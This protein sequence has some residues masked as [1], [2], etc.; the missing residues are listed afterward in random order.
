MKKQ[1][2]LLKE[3]GGTFFR[4]KIVFSVVS[5]IL[6]YPLSFIYRCILA[7]RR[8]SIK[9][10]YPIYKSPIPVIAVGNIALGGTGK[11]PITSHILSLCEQYGI[12]ATLISRGY[13]GKAKTY[14]VNLNYNNDPTL[15]GDE[16]AMMARIHKKTLCLVDPQRKRAMLYA[17][18]HKNLS[19]FVLDDAMQHIYVAR[20][21][22]V[23]ILTLKDICSGWDRVLPLGRWREGAHALHDASIFCIRATHKE[24]KEYNVSI[25]ER[26]RPYKKAVYIFHVE[27]SGL[28]NLL[29][30]MPVNISV[31]YSIVC[32]VGNPQSFYQGM[33][34]Y[35]GYPP[36]DYLYCSD[37]ASQEVLIRAIDKSAT[38][39]VV[40][41]SKDAI[42]LCG[43]SY[44]KHIVYAR[45]RCVFGDMLYTQETFDEY[46]MRILTNM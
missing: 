3:E 16:P 45:A 34:D 12:S 35:L 42:K 19:C 6:L 8:Y 40:C 7:V 39:T 21:A 31:P 41:T 4:M 11:T 36:V 15:V 22:N 20:D 9:H 26:M 29:D 44:A 17:L 32:G 23:V 13:G 25:D 30:D 43:R 14:P 38:S 46:C 10:L 24:W 5:Y 18:R 2:S 1:H 33:T 28:Y 37:H 27:V